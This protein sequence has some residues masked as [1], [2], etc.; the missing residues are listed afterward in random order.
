MTRYEVE[1]YEKYEEQYRERQREIEAERKKQQH[2][3][4]QGWVCPKC[5]RVYSPA[6]KMCHFCYNRDIANASNVSQSSMGSLANRVDTQ[7]PI[8]NRMQ[9]EYEK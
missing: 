9:C 3:T 7:Q 1:Q 4:Q 2:S 5:G 6:V 8:D